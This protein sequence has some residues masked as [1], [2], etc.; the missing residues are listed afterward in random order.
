M[1][2]QS[3]KTKSHKNKI[4]EQHDAR[5]KRPQENFSSILF[6][7]RTLAVLAWIEFVV[8][9]PQPF[10]FV[11]NESFRRHFKP[12]SICRKTL[13][14]YLPSLMRYVESKFKTALQKQIAIVLDD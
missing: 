13:V 5:C 12:D 10:C 3:T 11:K 1:C 4:A 8:L 7:C 2:H 9:G 6:N 14:L